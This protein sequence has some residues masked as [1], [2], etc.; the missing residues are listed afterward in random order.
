MSRAFY[1][2]NGEFHP[3]IA[4]LDIPLP[5][6]ITEYIMANGIT[7]Y[8]EW[9]KPCPASQCTGT[10]IPFTAPLN[11]DKLYKN[12]GVSANGA[13]LYDSSG[14]ALTATI[15]HQC[16]S[17][18]ELPVVAPAGYYVEVSG[19]PANNTDDYYLEFK[20]TGDSLSDGSMGV[21]YWWKEQSGMK[22][23]DLTTLL[24]QLF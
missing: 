13:E 17:F 8:S 21:C 5:P 14:G 4:G 3:M 9:G 22:I 11:I 16:K 12:V 2:C 20:V 1:V 24:C 18:S 6:H 7:K 19:D 23:L 15:K 10:L